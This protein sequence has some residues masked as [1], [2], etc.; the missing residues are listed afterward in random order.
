MRTQE[1]K[2]AI[3]RMAGKGEFY[4]YEMHKLLELKKIAVGIGRLYS[5]LSEMK[6]EGLLKDRWEKSKSGPKRRVYQ[7]D[8]K[9]AEAREDILIDAI[10]TVHEFYTEYL[11]S[12]PPEHSAFNEIG[13]LL[14]EKIPKNANIAY[15]ANR[16]SGPVRKLIETLQ[17][18]VP[19]GKIYAILP[20]EVNVSLEME[21]VSVVDGTIEDIPMKDGF[22]DLIIVTGDIKSDCLDSCLGEWKRVMSKKGVL[23]VVTPSALL[24]KYQDPLD[25]REFVEQ[26]EHPRIESGDGFDIEIL[27]SE[28]KKYFKA[29]DVKQI[30]HISIVR[31]FNPIK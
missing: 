23:G 14:V 12:L 27:K 18:E 20:R 16:V 19:D 29:V 2:T 25:I 8:K 3:L 28:M 7:I 4:G 22:L 24:T 9:G 1:L 30:I 15:V 6:E 31:G 17:S 21:N 5:I 10:K 13:R 11:F 26:R